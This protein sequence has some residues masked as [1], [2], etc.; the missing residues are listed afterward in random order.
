MDGY[1]TLTIE[2]FDAL[3]R[4]G[5]FADGPYVSTFGDNHGEPYC[6]NKRVWGTLKDGRKVCS[7]KKP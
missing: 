2:E 7:E 3:T 1:E 4:A 6:P 5:E